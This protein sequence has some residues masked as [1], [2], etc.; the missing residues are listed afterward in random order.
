MQNALRDLINVKSKDSC[1]RSSCDHDENTW[2]PSSLLISR[3]ICFGGK[4]CVQ[5]YF[6]L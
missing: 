5:I 6:A 4:M 2:F 1:I 3:Q